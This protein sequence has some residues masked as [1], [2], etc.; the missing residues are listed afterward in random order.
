MLYYITHLLVSKEIPYSH[1]LGVLMLPSCFGL[2]PGFP[3]LL[4]SPGKSWISF[5]KI[6]RP[7]KLPENGVGP[8]KSWKLL[9]KVLESPGIFFAMMWEADTMMQV[10]MPKFVKS[11]LRFYLYI[12]KNRWRPGLCPYPIVT[13]VCLYI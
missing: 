11:W 9:L 5:C 12:R 8:G 1:V 10:G 6:S 7:W 13:A 3:R 4:E 2:Q